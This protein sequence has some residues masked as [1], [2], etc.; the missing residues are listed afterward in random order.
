VGASWGTLAAVWSGGLIQTLHGVVKAAKG[1]PLEKK[2]T[3]SVALGAGVYFAVIAGI[4]TLVA[5]IFFYY[6]CRDSYSF[7]RIGI[8]LFALQ[9]IAVAAGLMVVFLHVRPNILSQVPRPKSSPARRTSL[10]ERVAPPDVR[11]PV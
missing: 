3:D 7:Q 6:K 2:I 1:T 4:L 9:V 5:G 11:W 10:I 8:L